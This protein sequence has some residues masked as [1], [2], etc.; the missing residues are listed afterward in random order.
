[1]KQAEQLNEDDVRDP[2]PWFNF[3]HT[4]PSN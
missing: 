4:R 2:Q 1:M 3:S